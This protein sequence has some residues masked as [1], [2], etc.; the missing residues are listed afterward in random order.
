MLQTTDEQAP[1]AKRVGAT[2]KPSND[3][4]EVPLDLERVDGQ[5]VHI[6]SNLSPK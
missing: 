1:D 3:V 2:F 6:G 4:K 5:A